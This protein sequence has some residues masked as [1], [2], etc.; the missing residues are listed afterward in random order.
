MSYFLKILF[1]FQIFAQIKN[2]DVEVDANRQHDRRVID[3]SE[4]EEKGDKG[5]DKEPEEE[6]AGVV[7]DGFGNF[8]KAVGIAAPVIAIPKIFHALNP[9]E[10]K[11]R[12]IFTPEDPRKS[13]WDSNP[14]ATREFCDYV[15]GAVES[16]GIRIFMHDEIVAKVL[17]A[18]K[19]RLEK[20]GHRYATEAKTLIEFASEVGK[21]DP[22]VVDQITKQNY[23]VMYGNPK[24][25]ENFDSDEMQLIRSM[26][27]TTNAAKTRF[28]F[29]HLGIA[30]LQTAKAAYDSVMEQIPARATKPKEVRELKV[31]PSVSVNLPKQSGLDRPT[32]TGDDLEEP[33]DDVDWKKIDINFEPT[34]IGFGKVLRYF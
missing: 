29:T 26:A 9:G 4:S 6:S 1:V 24:L 20:S 13:W 17:A 7:P 11:K 33:K 16:A 10:V 25:L 21:I 31:A 12:E 8:A 34:Y 27:I 3:W 30:A 18:T 22:S 23:P 2:L 5:P 19:R 28:R 32:L 14:V 15:A